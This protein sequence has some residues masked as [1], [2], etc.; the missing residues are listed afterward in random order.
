MFLQYLYAILWYT[1]P[2]KFSYELKFVH[3]YSFSRPMGHESLGLLGMG[4]KLLGESRNFQLWDSN[5]LSWQSCPWLR[6]E[7]LGD[8]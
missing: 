7:L 5:P 6:Q 8:G 3:L 1:I 2:N 4:Q